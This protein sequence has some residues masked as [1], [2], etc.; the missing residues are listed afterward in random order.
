[1]LYLKANKSF[2]CEFLGWHK[3]T[4]ITVPYLSINFHSTCAR[5]GREIL[6]DSQGNWFATYSEDGQ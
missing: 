3:P 1:M 6:Q 2:R 4:K 5:C